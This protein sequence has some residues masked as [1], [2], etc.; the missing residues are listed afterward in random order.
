MWENHHDLQLKTE[1]FLADKNPLIMPSL[2]R[3]QS[4]D[5]SSPHFF[6]FVVIDGAQD[7]Q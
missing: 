1:K 2:I 6:S 4:M 5:I 7:Q 3:L